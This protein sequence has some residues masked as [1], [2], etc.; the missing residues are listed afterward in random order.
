M[1]RRRWE[2]EVG[3]SRREGG[4]G[5]VLP[6]DCQSRVLWWRIWSR[7][8]IRYSTDCTI[9]ITANPPQTPRVLIS[10]HSLT[11]LL[12]L[13]KNATIKLIFSTVIHLDLVNRNI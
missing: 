11:Y 3:R 4:G 10:T 9:S 1:G 8:R 5:A 6:T 12:L 2:E 7:A 13:S